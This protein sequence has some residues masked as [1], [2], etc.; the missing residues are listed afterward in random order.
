MDFSEQISKKFRFSNRKKSLLYFCFTWQAVSCTCAKWMQN[1]NSRDRRQCTFWEKLVTRQKTKEKKHFAFKKIQW[2][3]KWKFDRN[4]RRKQIIQN[5]TTATNTSLIF[6]DEC[7]ISFSLFSSLKSMNF[8]TIGL[9]F[10]GMRVS[11]SRC[12]FILRHEANSANWKLFILLFLRRTQS[13][14]HNSVFTEPLSVM[15]TNARQNEVWKKWKKINYLFC[16]YARIVWKIK[17]NLQLRWSIFLRNKQINT[18]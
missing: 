6:S 18:W 14:D 3:V 1:T 4:R 10:E 5:M 8:V 17:N 12:L 11:R 13:F 2:R 15:H 7:T 16:G 9:L